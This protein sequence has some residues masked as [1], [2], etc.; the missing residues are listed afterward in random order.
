MIMSGN[1]SGI[2]GSNVVISSTICG[3]NIQIASAKAEL[4]DSDKEMMKE[5]ETAYSQLAEREPMIAEAISDL[6]TAIENQNKE[7]IGKKIL[8]LTTGTAASVLGSVLTAKLNKYL[9]A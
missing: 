9:P 8:S 7:T 5:L 1:Y 3:S 2:S 4:S 6:R